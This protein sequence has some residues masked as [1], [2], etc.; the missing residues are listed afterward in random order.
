MP[1]AFDRLAI[2][3]GL[4]LLG[5]MWGAVAALAGLNALYLCAS[6]IACAFILRDYRAGVVLLIL[7]MPLSTSAL[8]PHAILGITSLNPLNLL[9]AGTFAACLLQR[10]AD[11]NLSRQVPSPLVWLYIAPI[12]LGGAIGA[13]HVG[14]IAPAFLLYDLINFE[15]ATGYL[16]EMVFKPLLMVVFALL[17]GTAVSKSARPEGFLIPALVSI[18]LMDA[19]VIVYVLRSGI[20]L[21]QLASNDSREFLSELGLHANDLGGGASPGAAVRSSGRDGAD[22]GGLDAHVF[23]RRLRRLSRRECAVRALAA[24]RRRAASSGGTPERG[25]L[26]ASWCGLRPDGF[27]GGRRPERDQ[28]RAHRGA[29]APAVARGAAQPDLRQRLGFHPLVGTDETRDR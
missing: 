22:G 23:A 17:V 20:A 15:D 26:G 11:G 6:L 12:L 10:F 5:A 29:L 21:G 19:M 28:R 16:R 3:A 1:L 14:E 24:Q 18:Y 25:G 7:L 9:L 27:R 8:F 4:A 2:Y 13:S